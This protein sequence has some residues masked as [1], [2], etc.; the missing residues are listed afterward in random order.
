MYAYIESARSKTRK[1]QFQCFIKRIQG[2]FLATIWLSF[3]RPR[4]AFNFLLV[5]TSRYFWFL[6]HAIPRSGLL[7]WSETDREE[8]LHFD[9]YLYVRDLIHV[10]ASHDDTSSS[11][12]HSLYTHTHACSS[13]IWHSPFF[14]SGS[15][16][17]NFWTDLRTFFDKFRVSRWLI[18]KL[19]S[20]SLSLYL[21]VLV[22]LRTFCRQWRHPIICSFGGMTDRLA[23]L[24]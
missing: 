3:H 15:G 8:N 14:G 2:N 18:D 21:S 11:I 5:R 1:R 13:L 24:R 17:L 19:I 23:Q 20:G 12:R 10:L 22:L 7:S 16:G 4:V 6:L 9:A